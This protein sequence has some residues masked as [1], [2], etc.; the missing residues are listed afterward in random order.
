[1]PSPVLLSLSHICIAPLRK[2]GRKAEKER[3]EL[4][5]WEREG[6]GEATEGEMRDRPRQTDPS[7][8]LRDAAASDVSLSSACFLAAIRLCRILHVGH[9]CTAVGVSGIY[10]PCIKEPTFV[11]KHEHSKTRNNETRLPHLQS[12]YL[13]LS[14][15]RSAAWIHSPISVLRVHCSHPHPPCLPNPSPN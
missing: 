4:R 11:Q 12:Q 14:V 9:S 7:F 10:C 3:A 5:G 2:G 1:M 15:C 8:I 13:P 6:A